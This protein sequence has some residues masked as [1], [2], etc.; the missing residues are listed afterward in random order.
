MS[1]CCDHD[2]SEYIYKCLVSV[3]LCPAPAPAGHAPLDMMG[4][5]GHW[6]HHY[7]SIWPWTQVT[8]TGRKI[9]TA[10]AICSHHQ[11]P[12]AGLL[13]SNVIEM[14]LKVGNGNGGGV[15]DDD[16]N[17]QCVTVNNE[18]IQVYHHWDTFVWQ[19]T[20]HSTM[21]PKSDGLQAGSGWCLLVSARN[22]RKYQKIFLIFT[23]GPNHRIMNCNFMYLDTDWWFT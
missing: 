14:K 7:L 21:G 11:Q 6:S 10:A 17:G 23:V 9:K 13:P 18:P 1:P 15:A 2:N 4:R 12:L 16:N 5:H 22:N 3:S 19:N 8:W 20:R